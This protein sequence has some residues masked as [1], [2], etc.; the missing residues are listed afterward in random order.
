[1]TGGGLGKY[2]GVNIE[3]RLT[4]PIVT[5]S[6]AINLFSTLVGA[7]L[8]LVG[9][10]LA[11]GRMLFV[12]VVTLSSLLVG[13]MLAI[14]RMIRRIARDLL[15]RF[16]GLSPSQ[17]IA[18]VGSLV[19]IGGIAVWTVGYSISRVLGS[20]SVLRALGVVALIVGLGIV[21]I[22]TVFYLT[23]SARGRSD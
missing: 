6:I 23:E 15:D 8:A 20:F 11:I 4:P 13:T 3:L 9:T 10:I 17:R 19:S 5:P 14:G 18:A 22:G 16:S 7:I 21:S 2:L 12:N 1:V